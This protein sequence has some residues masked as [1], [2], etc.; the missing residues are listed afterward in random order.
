MA[1]S[2][3]ASI[4]TML[5]SSISLA[6]VD[7]KNEHLESI[8]GHILVKVKANKFN[9]LDSIANSVGAKRTKTYFSIKG[10]SL[11][12][13]DKALDFEYVQ[14]IFEQSS[15]VDYAEPDY[16]YTHQ[17]V[18]DDPQFQNQWA[19]K[20]VGQNGGMAG[21]DINAEVMWDMETGKKEIVIGVIDTG[22]DYTHP[23]L[24][25]NM[26]INPGE[27]PNNGIDDDKNGY[28]DDI[29]GIN[30]ILANGDPKDDNLHGTHVAGIIG[31]KGNNKLGISGVAQN[32]TIAACK[33]LNSYG[34]G[35]ISDAIECM[36]YFA[37]LKSRTEHPLNIVATNNS[38]GGGSSSQ[39][40]KDAITAH[41]NLGIL[42][43]AAAG[44]D[45]KNN[46][47]RPSYPAT[48]DIDNIISVASTD[49]NDLLS[50]FSNYGKKTVHVAAPG[51][52]ILST[53]LNHDYKEL[54]GTSMATPH[55]SGL[56][57]IIYSYY[58]GLSYKQAKNLVMSG[59][60]ILDS[61]KEKTISGRRIK[62][63]DTDG[64][65]SITCE[66]QSIISRIEPINKA[67]SLK[68]NESIFLS[69]KYINCADNGG[70]LTVYNNEDEKI[71]L[72]DVGGNGDAEPGDGI[73]SLTWKPSK[74]GV[75]E[76]DFGNSDIVI[77]TVVE[78]EQPAQPETSL[79]FTSESL[80]FSKPIKDT[81]IQLNDF[82]FL[83]NERKNFFLKTK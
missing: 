8:K 80:A 21:A 14:D 41:K 54:S 16:I 34:S 3:F 47:I 81:S 39:S 59:G 58:T 83:T 67:Y 51:T 82:F 24:A 35:G 71:T 28:V 69:A 61:V 66:N 2:I 56:V 73:Y 26:W 25:D 78:E 52:K 77:V 18:V 75:Y 50:T 1:K 55:V 31:A 33:F 30:A 44:N 74:A 17:A 38:W 46:D 42:F 37:K 12:E 19:L 70:D 11:Y 36:D 32:V 27:I 45:A 4:L 22:V 20:N 6:S 68:L 29:H 23:D 7:L 43:I 13:F 57:A 10:L 40:M 60:D 9:I 5:L 53:V 76:L 48:Y 72:T 65:G 63:A 79:T 64:T 49:K 15:Y 62:G